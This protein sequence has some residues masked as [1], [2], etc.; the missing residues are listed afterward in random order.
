MGLVAVGD[1]P[2]PMAERTVAMATAPQC[3]KVIGLDWDNLEYLVA[4]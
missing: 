3:K 4:D 2:K 1:W